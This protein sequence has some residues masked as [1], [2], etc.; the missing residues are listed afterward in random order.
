MENFY[1]WITQPVPK[2]DVEI[3]FNIHNMIP[4]RIE[5][6]GVMFKSLAISI[7]ET[8]L[9]ED[10][11]ETKILL[12]D[13]DKK[14]HFDWCW[15]KMVSDFEKENILIDS[16]GDHQEY[17]WNFFQDSFYSQKEVNIREAIPHFIDE[18]FNLDTPFAKSDLDILTE[19][20]KTLQNK[21]I[22]VD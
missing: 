6:F 20:Y 19:L 13:K 11:S 14:N 17:M 22:H 8:Y 16:E 15:K 1:N 10:S 7:I 5:L 3:W 4:E 12:S 18:L 21:V 9:G 2:E